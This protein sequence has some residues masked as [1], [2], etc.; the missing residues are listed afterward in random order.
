VKESEGI[1]GRGT[2]SRGVEGWRSLMQGIGCRGRVWKIAEGRGRGRSVKAL[3]G[4]GAGSA[5]IGSIGEVQTRI[6]GLE[7]EWLRAV[8]GKAA[9]ERHRNGM[10]ARA[11]RQGEAAEERA[12]DQ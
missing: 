1:G 11:D 10:A 4:A 12:A 5:D 7:G 2:A 3:D 9:R 6:K 8:K